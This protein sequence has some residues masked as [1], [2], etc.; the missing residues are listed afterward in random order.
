MY[1]D[2]EIK[3][4]F[5]FAGNY[6]YLTIISCILS[7]IST[8]LGVVPFVCVYKVIDIW[9]NNKENISNSSKY[10]LIAL[11]FAVLSILVYYIALS[12]SHLAA[13]RIAKNMKKKTLHHLITLPI[14]YFTLNSSGKIRKIIDDNAG[15]TE[16][17][18][19]HQLPDF[20]AALVMP[21][22]FIICLFIF[23]PILGIVCL[24][25]L[26]LSVLFMKQMMGGENAKFM[27]K[28][29]T[30]LESMNK[31]AVEYIRGIPIIKVFN[32]S[33][34]SFKNFHKSIND[35]NEFASGYALSCRIPMTNFKVSLNSFFIFLIP[36]S[37]FIFN[38]T[39][40]HKKI[41]LD[42]FFYILFTPLCTN[43]VM[44]LIFTQEN[45]LQTKEAVRRISNLLNEQ[46][47]KCS[48]N[49]KSVNNFNIEIKDVSF[50]YSEGKTILDNINLNINE[51]EM[52]AIVGS[53]G[54]GK[55]TLASLIPRF[56]DVN[57]GSI[58]IG[59]VNIVDIKK[60]DL[61]SYITFVF[62]ESKLF[63]SSIA[64]NVKIGKNNATDEEIKKSL[65]I[66]QCNDIIEK[67]PDG[68]NTRI[69]S[70]G[71]HLS[72]GEKQRIALARAILKNSPIV[73]LDEATSSADAE[74]EYLIQKA[75]EKLSKGKTVLLIAHRLSTVVNTDKIVVMKKGK[76]VEVGSHKSLLDKDGVYANM[77]RQ[78]ESS[79]SWEI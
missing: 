12:F 16:D 22:I 32:Q 48:G 35:Y 72:G 74:N 68:I 59:G 50:A 60:E 27:S 2:N 13:F 3:R 17:F 69:G 71:V 24:I 41:F 1:Y 38:N 66:A 51:G 54:S 4:V 77:W 52:V 73:I 76:I 79:I 65:Q 37:I 11:I 26:F 78:H 39:S 25:P 67:M 21:I 36:A 7:G 34:F 8:I 20:I 47:L 63:K 61:M 70:K 40:N 75:F 62:Q 15:L 18:L 53:S 55:T 29:M 30:S 46:P 43:M 10:A 49:A 19:A 14:G 23:N 6:K 31:E 58:S 28:Y 33:I 56:F 45:L 42:M 9:I 5:E 64:E 57:K 44:K